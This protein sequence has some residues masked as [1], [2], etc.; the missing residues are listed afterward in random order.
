MTTAAT[1]DRACST[2]L[3]NK[4]DEAIKRLPLPLLAPNGQVDA[5]APCLLL[6]DER[7]WLGHDVRSAKDPTRTSCGCRQVV[8]HWQWT[9]EVG[10]RLAVPGLWSPRNH[11]NREDGNE[12]SALSSIRS[13]M[14]QSDQAARPDGPDRGQT[15][16]R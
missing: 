2:S 5:V 14:P 10:R 9:P 7:T 13:V 11:L 16:F 1:Q 12:S 3:M 15:K 8:R 6:R 4:R